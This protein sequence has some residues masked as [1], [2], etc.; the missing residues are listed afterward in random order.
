[1]NEG[2]VIAPDIVFSCNDL[3]LAGLTLSVGNRQVSCEKR[4]I[5]LT[6]VLTKTS[7]FRLKGGLRPSFPLLMCKIGITSNGQASVNNRGGYL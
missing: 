7:L 3:G 5:K 4:A 6:G 1:M 2:V